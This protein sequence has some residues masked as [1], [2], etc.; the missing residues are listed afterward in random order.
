M[1]GETEKPEI[2]GIKVV[3]DSKLSV[4]VRYIFW[5]TRYIFWTSDMCQRNCYV[6]DKNPVYF[7]RDITV[8][9]V[10]PL[11]LTLKMTSKF[12]FQNGLYHG[13]VVIRKNNDIVAFSHLVHPETMKTIM[14]AQT[15][16]C[17]IK[18]GSI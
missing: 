4:K 16:E 10:E 11:F 7:M 12:Y 18:S 14:K 9:Q 3:T 13:C 17:A 6:S 8:L 15:F 1:S 5:D 2:P